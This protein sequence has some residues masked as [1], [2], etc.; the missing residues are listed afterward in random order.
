MHHLINFNS[1]FVFWFALTFIFSVEIRSL[2]KTTVRPLRKVF[3]AFW[4]CHLAPQVDRT[5]EITITETFT[6]VDGG[7]NRA[8]RGAS[9]G[10]NNDAYFTLQSAPDLTGC[11]QLC[12]E[13]AGCKGIEY[14]TS[15]R[16]EVWIRPDGIGAST[17]VARLY[18]NLL[19]FLLKLVCG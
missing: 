2:P 1:L 5:K 17:S 14:H 12:E 10:D 16:C 11:K 8:C 19:P 3:V 15:G 7:V 4:C 13:T 18:L 9:S 6:P